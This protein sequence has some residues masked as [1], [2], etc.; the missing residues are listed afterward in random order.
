MVGGAVWSGIAGGLRAYLRT[1]VVIS[2]LMLNFIAIYLVGLLIIDTHSL[3]RDPASPT[4]PQGAPLP[5]SVALPKLFEQADVG[6]LIALAAAAVLAIVVR[7]TRWGFELRVIG[8]SPRAARYA[9][10]R[11]GRKIVAVMFISG[12]LAGL[13]GAIQV[14][15]VTQALDLGGLSPGSGTATPASSWR[16]WRGSASSRSLRSRCWSPRC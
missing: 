2:T 4:M 6:I 11:V 14:T 10:M 13:A 16:P 7:Y 5:D 1:D 8:D 3:W 12:A 9:G 15:S